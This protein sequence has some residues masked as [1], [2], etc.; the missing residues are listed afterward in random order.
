MTTKDSNKKTKAKL[1]RLTE[2]ADEIFSDIQNGQPDSIRS[3]RGDDDVSV[4]L[5]KLTKKQLIAHIEQTEALSEEIDSDEDEA[6]E[7]K[8]ATNKKAL[9]KLPMVLKKSPVIEETIEAVAIVYH[10]PSDKHPFHHLHGS[11]ASIEINKVFDLIKED[12]KKD[13]PIQFIHSIGNEHVLV[14]TLITS[15]RVFK[16]PT[17]KVG[18]FVIGKTDMT[19][20]F[21]ARNQSLPCS[22]SSTN[23]ENLLTFFV[24]LMET[25]TKKTSANKDEIL[26]KVAPEE[27]LSS[28][29]ENEENGDETCDN[30]INF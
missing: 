15:D 13:K 28:D 11:F 21:Q 3:K 16:V 14:D 26:P 20:N 4:D 30:N 2:A 17:K 7:K 23:S 9:K 5:R 18:K 10:I 6:E 12:V 29:N 22:S 27:V 25:A 24:N 1:N 8:K 19:E